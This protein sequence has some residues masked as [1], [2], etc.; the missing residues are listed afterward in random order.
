VNHGLGIPLAE[1][2]RIEADLFGLSAATSG[3]KEGVA[4][5]LAKR[6]PSFGGR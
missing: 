4:A 5:F 3:M 1:A 2:L 6:P